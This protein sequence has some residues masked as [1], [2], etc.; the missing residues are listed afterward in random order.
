[1]GYLDNNDHIAP[2]ET[3]KVFN[4][5]S[6]G[7]ELGDY[8]TFIRVFYATTTT[9]PW[10]LTATVDEEE[11]WVEQGQFGE[12]SFVFVFDNENETTFDDDYSMQSYDFTALG[13]DPT[14]RQRHL[15]SSTGT[16][17]TSDSD[18]PESDM[19]IV[20]LDSYTPLDC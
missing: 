14:R 4:R 16:G 11:A 10:T 15:Y 9:I 7:A 2:P 20:S 12:F 19:F 17:S 18:L 1:M 5:L 13:L 3:Y 8:S 6:D